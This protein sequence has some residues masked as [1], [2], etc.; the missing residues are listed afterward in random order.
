VWVD[1]QAIV[2]EQKTAKIKQLQSSSNM[3]YVR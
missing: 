3:D 2:A 1:M